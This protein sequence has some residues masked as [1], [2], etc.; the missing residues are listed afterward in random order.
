MSAHVIEAK[1]PVSE[2]M[3]RT[4]TFS[5]LCKHF[6]RFSTNSTATLS[7]LFRT[8][9]IFIIEKNHIEKDKGVAPSCLL[10]KN[11]VQIKSQV[12][13]YAR[14]RMVLN[15]DFSGDLVKETDK[16]NKEE[17]FFPFKEIGG[18][19]DVDDT[20][21]R[22]L[23]LEFCDS[24]E[25]SFHKEYELM[26][27]IDEL[28]GPNAELERK[29][30]KFTISIRKMVPY[31][32]ERTAD[33]KNKSVLNESIAKR[34]KFLKELR[35]EDYERFIWLLKELKIRYIPAKKTVRVSKRQNRIN[36]N[37]TISDDIRNKKE[38]E[39]RLVLERE[40]EEYL[41]NKEKILEDIEKEIE[42][43]GLN[44]EEILQNVENIRVAR[45]TPPEPVRT[46]FASLKDWS[47]PKV[48]PRFF[49]LK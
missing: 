30:V 5:N 38:E 41:M 29:I 4:L 40:K 45:E 46:G 6:N 27:K 34:K 7:T 37:Q 3:Q 44:K 10:K 19:E 25:R 18:L 15:F 20:V 22:L 35:A 36:E 9:S 49:K 42:E 1:L 24:K 28:F 43:Y 16:V 48:P 23:S 12:R 11:G 2:N 32:L 33:K 39:L 21:I 8:N 14:K 31:C 47:Y 26:K 17:L 13:F